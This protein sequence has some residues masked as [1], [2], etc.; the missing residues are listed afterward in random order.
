MPDVAFH[1]LRTVD[2]DA[3]VARGLVVVALDEEGVAE[4]FRLGRR[5]RGPQRADLFAL[6][7]AGR[8]AS[9][10]LTGD[11]R[12]RNAAKNEGVEVHGILWLLD[13]LIEQSLISEAR[14][15]EA[16]EAMVGGGARLPGRE[17]AKRLRAW[18]RRS[19]W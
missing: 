1:E 6:V 13:R 2:G 18:R 19:R 12:L 14:A 10:L 4:A 5:Y 3:L 11:R 17:V 9:D 15:A 8:R 7:Y 16:I